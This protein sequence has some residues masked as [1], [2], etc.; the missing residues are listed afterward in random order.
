MFPGLAQVPFDEFCSL[1]EAI[2]R[3]ANLSNVEFVT[4]HTEVTG[5]SIHLVTDSIY[6]RPAGGG[7]FLLDKIHSPKFFEALS[8]CD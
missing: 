8:T 2:C 3:C 7:M 4:V 6:T 5:Q 1:C